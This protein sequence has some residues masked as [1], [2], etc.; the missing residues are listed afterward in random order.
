ML[1]HEFGR[2]DSVYG[3]QK[4]TAGL[5]LRCRARFGQCLSP[6]IPSLCLCGVWLLTLQDL[7][8]GFSFSSWICLLSSPCPSPSFNFL[9]DFYSFKI[10]QSFS[11]V[12]GYFLG[13]T[14]LIAKVPVPILHHQDSFVHSSCPFF[15]VYTEANSSGDCLLPVHLM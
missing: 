12:I 6:M 3:D 15:M 4:S 8:V 1:E 11:E 5:S 2:I 9:I 10:F 14:A 13:R 7:K